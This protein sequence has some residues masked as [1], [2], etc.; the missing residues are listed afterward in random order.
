MERRDLF[1]EFADSP[2]NI[3]EQFVEPSGLEIRG[4]ERFV[5]T[6]TNHLLHPFYYCAVF[7]PDLRAWKRE[8]LRAERF[9]RWHFPLI[10]V[11][12]DYTFGALFLEKRE[13]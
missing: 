6:G 7:D 13:R 11:W 8:A 9:P 10:K 1:R 5:D 2:K 3:R 12:N 4:N